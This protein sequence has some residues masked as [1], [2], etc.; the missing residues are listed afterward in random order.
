[1]KRSHKAFTLIELLVVMA[2]IAIL[3]SF[4]LPAIQ[5]AKG[6][7]RTVQASNNIR[8]LTLAWIHHA[9]TEGLMMPWLTWD[10][11]QPEVQRYWFATITDDGVNPPVLDFDGGALAPFMEGNKASFQDPDFSLADLDETRFETL[12]TGYAYN[13]K[14]LGPGTSIEYDALFNWIGVYEPGTTHPVTGA[15]VPPPGY[16]FSSLAQTTRTIIFADSA[17]GFLADF[18]PGVRENWS[19]DA[20]SSGNP[21]VHFRH[22]GGIANVSFADGHVQR[23]RWTDNPLDTAALPAWWTAAHVDLFLQEKLGFIGL[24][25]SLYN[26]DF[27]ETD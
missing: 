1:M 14:Y 23:Y 19:L 7:A 3:A 17:Q 15:V 20:P 4:L 25:D 11:A 13:A 10:P 21:T 27:E 16:A 2:I 12:T 18:S 6:T 5:S 22:A 9:D 24:D 26:R 8:Q